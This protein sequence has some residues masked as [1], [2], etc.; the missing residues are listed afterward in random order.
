MR[1]ITDPDRIRLAVEVVE[2]GE[3]LFETIVE[4]ARLRPG[5]SNRP[6]APFPAEQVTEAGELFFKTLR[7][8]L[9]LEVDE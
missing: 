3:T 2:I 4:D 7:L 6:D 5:P 1:T 9:G 8:L